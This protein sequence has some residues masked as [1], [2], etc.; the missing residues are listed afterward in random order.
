[1]PFQ[2]LSYFIID[3]NDLLYPLKQ[4]NQIMCVSPIN[5]H[6]IDYPLIILEQKALLNLSNSILQDD[7][8]LLIAIT[9]VYSIV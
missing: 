1:M 4:S 2:E 7:Q 8:I 6:L 5:H 3:S 9:W